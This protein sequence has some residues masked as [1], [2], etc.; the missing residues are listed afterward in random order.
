MVLTW[1]RQITCAMRFLRCSSRS[2]RVNHVVANSTKPHPPNISFK[3][4][5]YQSHQISFSLPPSISLD[6]REMRR[7]WKENKSLYV[8]RK[9]GW[10]WNEWT[11]P[12]KY[13]FPSS[14]FSPLRVSM[15]GKFLWKSS[16]ILL[17]GVAGMYQGFQG[18]RLVEVEHLKHEYFEG[19][20]PKVKLKEILEVFTEIIFQRLR[21]Y[22]YKIFD[23][24][25][26]CC[27]ILIDKRWQAWLLSKPTQKVLLQLLYRFI[28]TFLL[29]EPLA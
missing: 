13:V 19:I 11:T 29:L 23:V 12:W 7:W 15:R 14:L 2:T 25:V 6:P 24:N 3:H 26:V 27:W 1:R 9:R 8:T 28:K 5:L 22:R 10:K 4:F 20:F 18:W 16:F 17:A 21:L